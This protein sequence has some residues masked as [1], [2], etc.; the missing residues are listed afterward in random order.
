MDLAK[1]TNSS[2]IVLYTTKAQ[3]RT[4]PFTNMDYVFIFGSVYYYGEF[5]WRGKWWWVRFNIG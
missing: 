2:F 1:S 5:L 4:F 3:Y